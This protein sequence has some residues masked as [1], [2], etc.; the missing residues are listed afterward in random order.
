MTAADIR[1]ASGSTRYR[2]E[3]A[4]R[5]L[6]LFSRYVHWSGSTVLDVGCGNGDLAIGLAKAGARRVVGID[7]DPVRIECAR[8]NAESE[9][10]EGVV[11]FECLDF[12]K[13][14][15][16]REEFDLA[17]S[18][19]TFEHVL[20]PRACLRKIFLSLK[21]GCT[22]GARFGPLWHSPYGA[23][24]GEFTPV[25]WVHALFPEKAVLRVRREMYRPDQDVERYE[26]IDGHLNRMTFKRFRREVAE[27]G[28]RA[29]RLRLN[30]EKDRKWMGVLKPLNSV[31]GH[32]P[33]FR[34]LCALSLMAVL[35]R[36]AND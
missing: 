29:E 27:A 20:D 34:E 32:L 1:S 30:P 3:K 5:V 31:L 15:E 19:G 14:F 8:R 22:F 6:N 23:H 4:R 12:A 35:R 11:Q 25:P 9:G 16:P 13:R 10:V 17:F 21:P 33:G 24:T 28:F 18:I 7:V 26:D 2:P 36:P